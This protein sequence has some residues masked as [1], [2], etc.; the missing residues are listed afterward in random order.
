MKNAKYENSIKGN[1]INEIMNTLTKSNQVQKT[2]TL[3]L[4]KNEYD[5]LKKY[6]VELAAVKRTP[7][8]HHNQILIRKGFINGIDYNMS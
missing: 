8:Y 5:C 7:N 2:K 3:D 1:Q 4:G 6:N